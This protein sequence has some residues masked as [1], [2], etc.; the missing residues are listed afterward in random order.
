MTNCSMKKVKLLRHQSSKHPE[1]VGKSK[2]YFEKK[3][4]CQSPKL[5]DFFKKV[6]ARNSETMRTCYLVAE[7]IAKIGTLQT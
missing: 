1:S 5:A 7:M 6:Q 3:L 4:K 2:E